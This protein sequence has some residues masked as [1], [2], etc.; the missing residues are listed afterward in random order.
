MNDLNEIES[1]FDSNSESINKIQINKWKQSADREVLGAL[2]ELLM[3]KKYYTRIIPKLVFEDYYPFLFDYY[4]K[5]MQNDF[6]GEW[7]HSS[8]I[9]AYELRGFIEGIWN[10]KQL[11][12][13]EKKYLRKEIKNRLGKLC[14]IS[15]RPFKD[16]LINGLLEHLFE[17][18]TIRAYFKAWEKKDI[19]DDFFECAV[20]KNKPIE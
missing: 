7:T 13:Q 15:E 17:N 6:D 14:L 11:S 1:I 4:I 10:D 12:E 16:V 5:C 18:N 9:A 3:D 19:L 20:D 2:V 8:Y